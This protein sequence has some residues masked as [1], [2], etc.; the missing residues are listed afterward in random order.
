MFQDETRVFVVPV[1]I[2]FSL[3]AS[4]AYILNDIIDIKN[5]S[6]HPKKKLRPIAA[7]A[8]S[9]RAAAVLAV[10]LAVF[11]F[12]LSYRIGPVYLYFVTAYFL[13]QAAYSFYLKYIPIVDI[14]CI[15]AGFIIRIL[16]GGA[17]FKV[18]A[19]SWLLMTMFMISLVLASGKRLGEVS[20]L[21]K[22]I[23]SH[24]KSLTA[25]SI[26]TLN[27][28]LTIS[29]ASALIA[30]ALYTVEQYQRLVYTIPI[31]TFGLFRYLMH[32]KQGTADPTEA[33][34]SDVWL[35]LTVIIWL[36]LVGILR[37]YP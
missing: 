19:S 20:L 7:G 34:T 36:V 28:I 23:E 13:L 1:F 17:A 4:S 35:A 10:F 37:Y 3:C 6:Y 22:N 32:A 31:V 5:D 14:F 29:S 26:S 9:R 21:Q 15:S 8:I 33:M 18:E 16:A 11:S 25:Y 30:Y 12:I 24:R 2:S 27:E